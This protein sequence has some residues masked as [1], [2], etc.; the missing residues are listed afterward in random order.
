MKPRE[1]TRRFEVYVN[2]RDRRPP[3]EILVPG[4][5][6]VIEGDSFFLARAALAVEV[7]VD[8]DD[9]RPAERR[10]VS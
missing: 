2:I 6:Q 3:F 9:I 10:R 5:P 1:P 8:P 7:Q 4:A